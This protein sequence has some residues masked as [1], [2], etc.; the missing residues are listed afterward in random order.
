MTEPFF[1][2]P[3]LNSPYEHP[4]RHWELDEAGQPTNKVVEHRR[5]AKFI[6]PI[7]KP[8]RRG[9]VE[10][11]AEMVFDAEAQSISTYD[12]QYDPT[13]IIND[14]RRRVDRWRELPDPSHWKVTPETA[15]LLQHWRHHR[16]KEPLI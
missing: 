5:E 10:A 16:F 6:S 3:V 2:S 7:P 13:P 9:K 8:K 11:Q 1:Q 4:A 12:Q 15:R 14:L